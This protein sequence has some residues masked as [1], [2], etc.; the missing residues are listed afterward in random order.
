MIKEIKINNIIFTYVDIQI[1]LSL[2][3]HISMYITFDTSKNKEHKKE[4]IDLY[5][6]KS[7]FDI[8]STTFLSKNNLIKS[9]D[10]DKS[11]I[12]LTIKTKFFENLSQ[13][14]RRDDIIND[15]LGI[16]HFS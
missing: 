11:Y 1:Q 13:N 8:I 16:H 7:K 5:E 12:T 15:I 6:S 4:L 2:G 10:I 9:I 3:T 14:I